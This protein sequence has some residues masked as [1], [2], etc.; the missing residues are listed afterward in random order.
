MTD[1][2]CTTYT[3]NTEDKYAP[4]QEA[5]ERIFDWESGPLDLSGLG[6]TVLPNIPPSVTELDVSRN[7][8][9]RISGSSI[10]I[11]LRSLNVADNQLTELPKLPATM[12]FLNFS[13][14]HVTE[15][16]E[17]YGDYGCENM[18]ELLCEDN[19][20]CSFPVLPFE[21]RRL[22]AN[23]NRFD[24]RHPDESIPSYLG[25]IGAEHQQTM[26]SSHDRC[27]LIR[28]DLQRRFPTIA[29]QENLQRR[30]RALRES[31]RSVIAST[32]TSASW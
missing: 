27:E 31:I 23:G 26:Q 9:T 21:L 5:L 32:S 2:S 29:A 18:R 17:F 16:P 25:R 12:A 7:K 6:L 24:N 30:Q 3:D 4:L 1:L 8:L 10:P 13:R 28:E 15:F 19:G 20:L 14:N 22:E 11:D